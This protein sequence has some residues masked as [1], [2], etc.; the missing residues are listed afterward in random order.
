MD[1]LTLALTVA[2]L[3]IGL[4]MASVWAL[5]HFGQRAMLRPPGPRTMRRLGIA[6]AVF[7]GLVLVILIPVAAALGDVVRLLLLLVQGV[8]LL[9]TGISIARQYR[10]PADE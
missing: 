7:G 9:A 4:V 6:I 3:A 1:R 2:F 5:A 8:V 10:P